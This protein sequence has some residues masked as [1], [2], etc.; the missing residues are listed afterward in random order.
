MYA[1]THTQ[2]RQL[3]QQTGEMHREQ[4]ERDKEKH[5]HT[6]T[7]TT[8]PTTLPI[9]ELTGTMASTVW[10]SVCRS[11]MS[12]KEMTCRVLPRPMLWARIQPNP[13]LPL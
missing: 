8:H 6:H 1:Y 3:Y 2:D 11:R 5:T 10:A 9:G 4:R 7:Q 13:L 12:M